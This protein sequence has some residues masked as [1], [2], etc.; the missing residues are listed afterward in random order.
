MAGPRD[1]II[2]PVVTEKSNDAM[3]AG[4]YTFLVDPR[5]NR[6]QIKLAIEEIFKVKVMRVNTVRGLGK[7]RRVGIH[8]GRR[9][10]WKKAV[11]TLAP[12]QKI[13]IFE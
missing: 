1:I 3:A 13:Q 4:K 11:A 12:G 8:E 9:P 5:A 6:T 2:R 10:S 7:M